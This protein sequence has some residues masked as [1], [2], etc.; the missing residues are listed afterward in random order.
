MQINFYHLTRT[1][2]EKA[3]PKLLEKVLEKEGRAVVLTPPEKRTFVNDSLWTYRPDSFLPHGSKDESRSHDHPIWVTDTLENPNKS[4]YLLVTG[5]L[6][7]PDLEG[8]THCLY[9]F[10][11]NVDEE[12]KEARASWQKVSEGNTPHYFQQTDK[13]AWEEKE[14]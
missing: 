11:S 7:V 3:L 2:M 9:L 10:D 12:L 4:D 13:G 14:V 5:G 6:P 8:F 1:P